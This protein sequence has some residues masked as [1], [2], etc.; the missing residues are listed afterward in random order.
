MAQSL[1]LSLSLFY[2]T[3]AQRTGRVQMSV[4]PQFLTLVLSPARLSLPT[5]DSFEPFRGAVLVVVAF[6]LS[7]NSSV[8]RVL[9]HQALHSVHSQC[10]QLLTV[11]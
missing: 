6:I 8:Q 4:S 5:L 2:R 7:R 10:T 9:L 1:L 3:R 11:V